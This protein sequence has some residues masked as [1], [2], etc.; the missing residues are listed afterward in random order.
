M[1]VAL[2]IICLA[3]MGPIEDE[4]HRLDKISKPWEHTSIEESIF[5]GWT[6]EQLKA[7]FTLREDLYLQPVTMSHLRSDD[8]FDGREKWGACIHPIRDQANCGSCWAH[9]TSEVFSD[10]VCIQGIDANYIASPQQL[11]SCDTSEYGCNGG[12]EQY[13]FMYIEK[14][15]LV[16]DSCYPYTS[17]NGQTGTCLT[18][19]VIGC[20]VKHMGKAGSTQQITTVE[21]IKVQVNTFGPVS[22][23]FRVYQDFMAYKSGVYTPVSTQ[24]L[25]L[26]AVKILGYGNEG[27]LDYWLIANSWGTRWGMEGFIKIQMNTKCNIEARIF[28]VDAD[29]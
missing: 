29:S 10:R 4:I 11:V 7:L 22:T 16:L 20:P 25:G 28:K 12:Y 23:G 8:N 9:A 19:K 26:H 6:I 3:T 13:A 5:Q 2:F 24:Y 14:N 1:I 18:D 27:G 15:G 17:G 21:A